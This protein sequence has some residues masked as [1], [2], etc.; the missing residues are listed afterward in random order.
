MRYRD[1][2]VL[3]L[4]SARRRVFRTVVTISAVALAT[5]LL[6]ALWLLVDIAN[7]SVL[8]HVTKGGPITAIRVLASTPDAGQ[9]EVDEFRPAGQHKISDQTVARFRAIPGVTHVSPVLTVGVVALPDR[10]QSARSII[11]NEIGVAA[12]SQASLPLEIVAGRLPSTANTEVA[13]TTDYVDRIGA[14][15]PSSVIGSMIDLGAPQL[16]AFHGEVLNRQ[17]WNRLTVVGVVRQNVA[18]G[19]FIVPMNIA[20]A[21]RTW[22][23]EGLRNGYAVPASKYSGA[24]IVA[25]TVGEMHLVRTKLDRLGYATSAPEKVLET[26]QRY[27]TVVDL[28]LGAIAFVGV[29]IAAL[30]VADAVSASIRERRQEIAVM[31]AIGARNADVRR[32]LLVEAGFIGAAGGIIGAAAGVAVAAVVVS[33]V[34]RFLQSQDIPPVGIPMSGLVPILAVAGAVAIAMGASYLPAQWAAGRSPTEAM[35]PE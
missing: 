19:L 13:V 5:A 9:L 32:W 34:N 33:A 11:T 30:A 17:R 28:V 7:S 16:F 1:G 10:T 22:A 25:T 14:A 4:R 21:D 12:A 2:V 27:A 6:V 29:I 20:Q 18:S 31:K 35:E 23:L 26:V 15:N 3:A 24:V 8:A